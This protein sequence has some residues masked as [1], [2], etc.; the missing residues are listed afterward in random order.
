MSN[1]LPWKSAPEMHDVVAA[2]WP[3]EYRNAQRGGTSIIPLADGSK[4]KLSAG[5]PVIEICSPE[6]V[7][8]NQTGGAV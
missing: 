8:G 1:Q 6:I 2:N 4:L 5:D 3:R 7:M